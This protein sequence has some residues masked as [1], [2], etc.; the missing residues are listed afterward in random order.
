MIALYGGSLLA[1]LLAGLPVAVCILGV[2][3]IAIVAAGVPNSMIV[4]RLVFGL[5][6]FLLIAIPLFLF[7]GNLMNASGITSRIFT[8]AEAMVGHWRAGF[9]QVNVVSSVMFSGMSGSALADAA[10]LGAIEIK[11]MRAAGYSAPYAAAVTAASA[12]IGPVIPPSIA[13]ILYAFIAD[14]SVGRMFLA[15]IVPGLLM[16]AA[17]MAT[18]WWRARRLDLP[19]VPK[20][21]ARVRRETFVRAL[22]ALLCPVVLIGGMRSGMFT[23]TELSAVGVIYALALGVF[24]HHEIKMGDLL[25]ACRETALAAAAIMLIVAAA[26]VFAWIAA[27]EQIPQTIASAVLAMEL[28]PAMFLL[29][30]NIVLLVLGMILDTTAILIL[31]APVLAPVTL[32]VGIDPVHFGIVMIVNMMVGLITPPVGMALF[33]VARIA[34]AKLWDVTREALPYTVALLGV[35]VLITYWPGLVL[36]LPDLVYGVAQ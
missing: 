14:V 25:A 32:A 13:A 30:V 2:G 20:A 8:F 4:E 35:L 7:M 36:F 21:S 6:S 10:G 31:V 1:F 16:A 12:T 22:P 5:D 9:A 19:R 23:A 3:V 11:A 18:V 26:H 33:V 17:L 28:S 27:R 24:L 15:G 29:V 34:D